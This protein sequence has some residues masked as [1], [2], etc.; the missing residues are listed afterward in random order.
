MYV[1]Q[2]L[3]GIADGTI[4]PETFGRTLP[5]G[6][7]DYYRRHWRSMHSTNPDWFERAQRPVVCMLAVAP[8]PLTVEK[9]REWINNS[10]QFDQVDDRLVKRVLNEWRQFLEKTEGAS[11]AW[12]LYHKSFTDFLGSE[13]A[14]GVD[15]ADFTRASVAA[16]G[17]KINWS[18]D[19]DQRL[20]APTPVHAPDPGGAGKS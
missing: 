18:T 16:V 17:T 11:P 6:L 9:L 5:T 12:R 2:V 8:Y 1:V 7:N 14:E 10:G 13:D 15:L 20:P 19:P 4:T 3:R